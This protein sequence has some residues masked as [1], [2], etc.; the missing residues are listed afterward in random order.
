LG[1]ETVFKG[2]ILFVDDEQNLL[3]SIKRSIIDVFP[4]A[5][6][7]TSSKTALSEISSGKNYDL[8]VS[9]MRM[10]EMNGLDF[11]KRVSEKDPEIIRILLT[12]DETHET[13]VRAINDGSIFYFLSKPVDIENDLIPVIQRGLKQRQLFLDNMRFRRELTLLNIRL[14]EQNIMLEEKNVEL[15]Q[16]MEKAEN[17]R[18]IRGK[19]IE[20]LARKIIPFV[21]DTV[22]TT[23]LIKNGENEKPDSILDE[24]KNKGTDVMN[25]LREVQTMLD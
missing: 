20:L 6:Y 15:S 7:Q 22:Y 19:I 11:L 3:S 18:K 25:L 5:E 16:L 14:T 23:M 1:E 24:L 4:D 13:A 9:D 17:D 2:K 8:I 12:A 10:P 21:A